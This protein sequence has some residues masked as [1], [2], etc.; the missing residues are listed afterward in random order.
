[1]DL[2]Q[3]ILKEHSKSQAV[4]IADWI[5]NNEKRFAHLMELFLK[6][7]Y[8][9]VQ[10]AAWIVSIA[11]ENHPTLLLPH[12]EVMVQR[13]KDENLPTAVKR[14][15]IRVLQNIAMPEKLHGPVMDACF[16]FLAD[17]KETIAV[18]CFSMAVLANLSKNYPEIKNE[19]RTVIEEA[20]QQ[21][22]SAGFRARARKVIKSLCL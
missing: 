19:L 15:V 22:A 18:R 9:V 14:N 17:P 16:Q 13:M 1:M 10:R 6:D 5:G 4:K 12:L 21:K 20:L 7:E 8:R 11:A 2:R 3:E